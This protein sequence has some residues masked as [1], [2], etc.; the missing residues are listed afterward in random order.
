MFILFFA[1]SFVACNTSP[2]RKSDEAAIAKLIDNESHFAAK[3]DSVQWK[4]CWVNSD[5]ASFIYT[6]V[7]GVQAYDDFNSLAQALTQAKPFEL[8]L[9]RDNYFYEIGD[10]IAFVSFDQQDNWGGVN[11]KTKETR[12]LRKV[13]GEWKIL[14]ASVVEVSSFTKP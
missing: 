10:D 1:F 9:A 12:T 6:S 14:H 11:R 13:N 3:G 2:D 4:T 8:K 5:D 7:S